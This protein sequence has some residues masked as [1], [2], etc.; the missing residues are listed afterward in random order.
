MEE[1]G[2]R[3][4]NTNKTNTNNDLISIVTVVFNGEQH[5][6]ETIKSIISQ[7]YKNVEYII[8]DGGS[9]D[10]TLEIIRQYSDKIDYW[11]SEKDEGISDAFNKG[12]NLA[13]GELIGLINADD[14]LIEG[15]LQ[16]V[17]NTYKKSDPK[18]ICA[19]MVILHPKRD[20]RT[21]YSTLASLDKEMTIAHPATFIPRIFYDKVGGYRTDFKVAM[22]YELMLR[23]K[24]SSIDFLMLGHI[25][26]TMRGGGVSSQ[27]YWAGLLEITKARKIHIPNF[28]NANAQFFIRFR[29]LQAATMRLLD[30]IGIG[31]FVGAYFKRKIF[32]SKS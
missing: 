27:H 19:G 6:E 23:M 11:I 4:N 7:S 29:Y 24:K 5:I 12:I 20:P 16:V 21:W 10:R 25:T 32:R 13:Q 28:S 26:T 9:T 15:S 22:D 1:G 31:K 3:L 2:L 30:R 14:Y 18:V 17:M 8:V